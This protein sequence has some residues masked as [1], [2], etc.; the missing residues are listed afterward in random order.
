M[1]SFSLSLLVFIV[2]APFL[3]LMAK[4]CIEILRTYR[5][6]NKKTPNP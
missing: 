4:L 6:H 5:S 3:A 1:S 2:V